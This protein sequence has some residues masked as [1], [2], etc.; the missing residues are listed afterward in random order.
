MFAR[1]LKLLLFLVVSGFVTLI[2][3]GYFG[4]LSPNQQ[5]LREPVI[6]NVD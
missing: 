4:D 3:F 1:V 6:L 2:G 5:E